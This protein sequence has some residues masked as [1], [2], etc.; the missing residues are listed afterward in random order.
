[1]TSGPWILNKGN[2]QQ[3]LLQFCLL[4]EILR[5]FIV[6]RFR[7][8]VWV[9]IVVR[10]TLTDKTLRDRLVLFI[11]EKISMKLTTRVPTI[12]HFTIVIEPDETGGYYAPSVLR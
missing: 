11:Q 12:R 6:K 1:M 9:V 7:Q 4:S 2:G 3:H 10:T 5:L 8:M